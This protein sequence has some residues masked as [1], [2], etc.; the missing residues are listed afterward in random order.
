MINMVSHVVDIL[1]LAWPGSVA[2]VLSLQRHRVNRLADS[3]PRSTLFPYHH[4]LEN[5]PISD[6]EL[7]T[8]E[9]ILGRLGLPDNAGMCAYVSA[10]RESKSHQL[11]VG[12][13]T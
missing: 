2:Y 8:C 10:T 4:T 7:T 6:S 13:E 3:N 12:V 1:Y 5:L 9:S 11:G